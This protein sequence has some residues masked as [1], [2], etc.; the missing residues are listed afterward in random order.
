MA[1]TADEVVLREAV[2]ADA[3][4]ISALVTAL[5]R[6]WIAPD[7]DEEGIVQLIESMTAARIDERLRDGHRHVVAERD[8]RIVGVAA[9]RLPSHLY[10]L[11]V[12]EDAQ[13]RGLARA[14]WDTVRTAADPAAPITVNASL[15]AAQAYHR[16]GFEATGPERRERGLR[17]LPMQWRPR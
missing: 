17:F 14:L 5:T 9:L 3:E 15:H 10:Y 11:F 7:C 12:A 8:G 13:R 2:S 4:A 1:A 6:R 16:L